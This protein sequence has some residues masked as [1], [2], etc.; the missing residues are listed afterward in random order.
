VQQILWISL[1]KLIVLHLVV[2]NSVFEISIFCTSLIPFTLFAISWHWT[3]LRIR[4]SKFS[5]P[6]NEIWFSIILKERPDSP[7]WSYALDSL[8]QKLCMHLYLHFV[9]QLPWVAHPNLQFTIKK[10][11]IIKVPPPSPHSTCCTYLTGWETET[12]K[13]LSSIPGSVKIFLSSLKHTEQLWDK[14]SI[15]YSG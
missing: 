13:V 5:F 6:R 3:L 11:I 14:Q 9:L 4:Y 10:W 2:L 15:F 12:P 8:D 1:Q 7:K